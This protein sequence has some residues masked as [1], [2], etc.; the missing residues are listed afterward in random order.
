[1]PSL[2]RNIRGSLGEHSDDARYLEFSKAFLKLRTPGLER[3]LVGI[4][5]L[6]QRGIYPTAELQVQHYGAQTILV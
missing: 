4:S 1:M 3:I 2:S 5:Q 6:T